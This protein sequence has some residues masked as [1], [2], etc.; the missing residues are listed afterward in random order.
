MTNKQKMVEKMKEIYDDDCLASSWAGSDRHDIEW[1][2]T[3][4]GE[5]VV[6]YMWCRKCGRV[7][8]TQS[9]ERQNLNVQNE[10]QNDQ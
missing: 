9:R 6:L 5:E 8:L 3:E 4:N 10:G 1:R 2:Y 7:A